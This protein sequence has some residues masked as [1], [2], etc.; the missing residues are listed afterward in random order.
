[1]HCDRKQFIEYPLKTFV[2]SSKGVK[3]LLSVRKRRSLKESLQSYSHKV[4]LLNQH[5]KL[6]KTKFEI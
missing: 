5:A 2:S 3:R 4:Q 6:R 1:M